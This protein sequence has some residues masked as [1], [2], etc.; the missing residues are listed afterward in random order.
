MYVR[1]NALLL[2]FVV[3]ALGACGQT[4]PLYLPEK[5][6]EEVPEEVPAAVPENA[7]VQASAGTQQP[8]S[9][10]QTRPGE[11]AEPSQ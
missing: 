4:G 11:T 1:L 3:C 2:L 8:E 5:V 10:T 7:P 6:P 9:T